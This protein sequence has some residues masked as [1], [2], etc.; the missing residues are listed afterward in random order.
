MPPGGPS[1]GLEGARVGAEAVGVS[2]KALHDL[3]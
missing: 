1:M 3:L 2:C